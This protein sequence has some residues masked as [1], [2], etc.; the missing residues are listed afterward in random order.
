MKSIYPSGHI[1]PNLNPHAGNKG[2]L[3]WVDLWTMKSQTYFRTIKMRLS[4]SWL[5]GYDWLELCSIYR[6]KGCG[7]HSWSVHT[8]RLWVWPLIR[9][10]M[11]G[12][13]SIFL[14]HWYFS[15]SLKINQHISSGKD[16]N[17]ERNYLFSE[18]LC[19]SK[20]NWVL[21]QYISDSTLSLW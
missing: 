13:K 7:F 3:F 9:V 17:K 19:T 11:G 4:S 12:N 6:P 8:P 14:S 10:C 20:K 1:K 15:V 2:T 21:G 5:G 18:S 16:L